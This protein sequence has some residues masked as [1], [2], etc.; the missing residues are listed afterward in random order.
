MV[1]SIALEDH[2]KCL[3]D[4]VVCKGLCYSLFESFS[5]ETK[6]KYHDQRN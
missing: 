6:E 5:M 1:D 2:D 4:T 3:G